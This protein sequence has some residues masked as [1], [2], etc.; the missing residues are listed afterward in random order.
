MRVGRPGQHD[1]EVG[2]T[3]DAIGTS[4]LHRQAQRPQPPG[5]ASS[6]LHRPTQRLHRRLSLRVATARPHASARCGTHLPCQWSGP[7]QRTIVTGLLP[8]WMPPANHSPRP[9]SLCAQSKPIDKCQPWLLH[10]P[11]STL[12]APRITDHGPFRCSTQQ[13][14]SVHGAIRRRRVPPLTSARRGPNLPVSPHLSLAD[15]MPLRGWTLDPAA[16]QL[17]SRWPL[18]VRSDPRTT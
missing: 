18:H 12:H 14:T 15:V 2:R 17:S 5:I 6:T 16:R 13:L 7:P 11:R 8:R 9:L 10:A 3:G 1:L 4:L